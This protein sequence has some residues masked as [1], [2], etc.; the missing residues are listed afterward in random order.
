MEYKVAVCDDNKA[1]TGYLA[2][3]LK[4]WAGKRE[5]SVCVS[6][7]PS[8]ESFLFRYAEDTSFDILLLDIEMGAMDGVTL[9]KRVRRDNEAVQIIFVTGYPDYIAEGYEVSALHYLLKPVS[10]E[11]LF[12]VLDRAAARIQKPDRTVVLPVDGEVLRVSA[13]AIR[14]VEAFSHSVAVVT[15]TKAYEVKK[16]LTEM[17]KLLGPEFIRCHRSYLV[18]LKAMAGLSK[19][20]VVLDTG[21]EL[22]LSR[23]AAPAVHRAFITYYTGEKHETV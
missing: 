2:G 18:G 21:E 5:H 12:C 13:D 20:K 23:S 15:K 9:A 19:T 4:D 7:F 14:Y 1:D 3:L 8:A 10:K 16:S 22:P 11:K 17:E 6:Q